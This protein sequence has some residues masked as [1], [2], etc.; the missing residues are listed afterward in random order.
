M[1]IPESQQRLDLGTEEQLLPT[2]MYIERLLAELIARQHQTPAR[3][4]P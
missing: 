1:Q 2:L 3:M 4:I